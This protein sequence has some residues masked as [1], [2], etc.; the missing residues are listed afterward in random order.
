MA[1]YNSKTDSWECVFCKIVS[2]EIS[3]PW[4]YREDEKYMAFLSTRPN[5]EWVT[6]VIP[7]AHFWSDVLDM[8]NTELQEFI[9]AAKKV[10]KV[11]INYFDDVGR[12]WLV[13]EWTGIDHAHIKLY[14]MHWTWHMKKWEWKQYLS[15]ND[16]YY[17]QYP[18]FISSN[19]WP[20]WNVNELKNLAQWLID[21][22]KNM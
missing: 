15:D 7:K 21:I 6:V 19:D 2:W 11:L 4:I 8:P 20:K 14:P 22:Q 16:E 1:N 17:T 5:M 9:L 13:M 18:W 3:T 12:V 10:S